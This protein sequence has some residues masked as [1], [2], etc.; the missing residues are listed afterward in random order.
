[1]KKTTENIA[2]K[3]AKEIVEAALSKYL[4]EANKSSNTPLG[5]VLSVD[6][7]NQFKVKL[8]DGS[9]KTVTYLGDRP[10]GPDSHVLI[11]GDFAR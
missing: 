5:Q 9:E 11:Q 1:M 10:I 8:S 6:E 4:S 2:A 7:N 3:V